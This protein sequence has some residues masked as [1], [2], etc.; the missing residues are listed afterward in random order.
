MVLILG[1][2]INPQPY[3]S[4][5]NCSAMRV[6]AAGWL[7]DTLEGTRRLARLSAKVTHNHPEGVKGAESVTSAIDHL[8]IADRDVKLI[9]L[10]DKLSNLREIARNYATLADAVWERFNQ[11]DKT[12]HQ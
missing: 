8:Q 5:G 3:Y 7:S 4:C 1:N 2:T 12:M 6:A 10:G 9:C 11:K